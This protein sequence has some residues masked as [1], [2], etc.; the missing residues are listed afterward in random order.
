[1]MQFIDDKENHGP[2]A[3]MTSSSGTT[4]LLGGQPVFGI[5]GT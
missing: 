1:M 5:I 3:G 2:S 4:V